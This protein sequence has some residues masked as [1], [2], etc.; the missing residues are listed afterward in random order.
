MH[1]IPHK[2]AINDIWINFRMLQNV[3]FPLFSTS[4][5]T[6]MLKTEVN[7]VYT[8]QRVSRTCYR[9]GIDWC[10]SAV[11]TLSTRCYQLQGNG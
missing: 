10:F 5:R 11:Q 9:A 1:S 8:W 3:P 2:P 4:I 6:G 7:C